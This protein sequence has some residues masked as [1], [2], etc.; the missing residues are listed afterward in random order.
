MKMQSSDYF[1]ILRQYDVEKVENKEYSNF[2]CN[3]FYL[4][5]MNSF[6]YRKI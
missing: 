5:W 3:S 1:P 4:G 2:L 6:N